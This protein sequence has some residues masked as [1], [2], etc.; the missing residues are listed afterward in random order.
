MYLLGNFLRRGR[1]NGGVGRGG[2]GLHPAAHLAQ[3]GGDTVLVLERVQSKRVVVRVR[4]Q[5]G[6][7]RV[8]TVTTVHHS[9]AVLTA[10]YWPL[11]TGHSVLA[12]RY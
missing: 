6:D 2:R 1:G 4:R 3:V 8:D 12:A 7:S 11:G 5:H 9:R 10:R